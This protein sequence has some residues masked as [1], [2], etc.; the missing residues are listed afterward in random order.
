MEEEEFISEEEDPF[1][2]QK[3][4]GMA[5][6]IR[7]WEN[8]SEDLEHDKMLKKKNKKQIEAEKQN[9]LMEKKGIEVKEN[10]NQN[11]TVNQ[12]QNQTIVVED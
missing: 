7:D 3:Q 8:E 11:Q 1:E 4:N 9:T 10:P 6:K 5:F 2:E 12:S